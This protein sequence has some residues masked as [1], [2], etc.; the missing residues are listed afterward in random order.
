[1]KKC[2]SPDF[3]FDQVIVWK[4][5]IFSLKTV[6]NL[7]YILNFKHTFHNEMSTLFGTKN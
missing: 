3:T 5:K 6:A 2:T 4:A 7:T 1:M